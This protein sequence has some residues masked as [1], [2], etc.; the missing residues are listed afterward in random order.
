M[1]IQKTKYE[2]Q[3][4]TITV[5]LAAE[6]HEDEWANDGDLRAAI[7]DVVRCASNWKTFNLEI[8]TNEYTE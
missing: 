6:N 7:N 1:T 5:K 3:D 2:Y 4:A 8:K